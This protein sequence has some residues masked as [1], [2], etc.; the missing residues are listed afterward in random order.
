MRQ[1]SAA[2]SQPPP[3]ALPE[4][5][6]VRLPQILKVLPIAKSTWWN[7]VASGRFPRPVK[8]GARISAW[9][10]E[11]IRELLEKIGRGEAA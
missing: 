8:L 11:A 5:G 1:R 10:V 7:G 9:P 4:T 3:F 6:F 2:S